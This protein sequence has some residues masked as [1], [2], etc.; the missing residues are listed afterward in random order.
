MRTCSLLLDTE[1]W[2]LMLDDSRNIAITDNIYSVAQ[3][4]ARVIWKKKPPGIPTNGNTTHTIVDDENYVQPYP[5][6][7]INYVIP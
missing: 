2:D 7:E 1:S 4:V 6:Y 5:E 3:D